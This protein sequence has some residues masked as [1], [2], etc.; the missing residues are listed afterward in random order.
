MDMTITDAIDAHSLVHD[1]IE[2]YTSSMLLLL[3]TNANILTTF[4]HNF[5]SSTEVVD[6][7]SKADNVESM[8]VDTTQVCCFIVT[9]LSCG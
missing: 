8:E 3:L 5:C 9:S 4:H 7:M 6:S 2:R 1:S